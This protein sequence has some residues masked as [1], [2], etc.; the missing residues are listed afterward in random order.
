MLSVPYVNNGKFHLSGLVFFDTAK[1]YY[2]FNTNQNLST[3]SAVIFKN[4][5]FG[6]Y[7]KLRP[8]SMSL[9]AWSPDD[10][11]LIRKSREVFEE[12]SRINTQNQKVQ[13]LGAVTVRGRM[14]S[15]KEKL[16]EQYS[17]GLFS[18]GNATI[19]DVM[20]DGANYAAQNI[21]S[22]LQSRVAGLQIT[23]AGASPTLS[24]RGSTPAVYLNEMKVEPSTISNLNVSEIAMVKVFSPGGSSVISGGAGGVIAVYTKRG[25]DR[26]PDPS[27]KGLEMARV[28]GFTVVREFYSPDYLINPEPETEDIRTTLF[29][30]PNLFG[31]REKT[32]FSIPFYNSDMTH[33]FRVILEGFNMDGKLVH[34]EMLVE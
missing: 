2:Q 29:W 10:S 26:A 7:R 25:V 23:N 11:S 32:R 13:Y 18:G 4:G 16:D 20:S 15:N 5:L 21:F 6:G 34:E 33:K 17:S 3:E 31:G 19:F 24:W 28:P 14:K 12:V 9:P 8:F 27:I 30:N 1:V 22:Y